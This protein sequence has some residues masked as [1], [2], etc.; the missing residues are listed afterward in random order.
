MVGLLDELIRKCENL[1]EYYFPY[2]DSIL[3]Y[4]GSFFVAKDLLFMAISIHFDHDPSKRNL[5]E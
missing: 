4:T 5:S 3:E 2:C 1:K